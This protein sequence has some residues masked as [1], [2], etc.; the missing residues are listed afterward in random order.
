MTLETGSRDFLFG[1]EIIHLGA[2]FHFKCSVCRVQREEMTVKETGPD[3]GDRGTPLGGT[4]Q[5]N[6][7]VGVEYRIYCTKCTYQAA[8]HAS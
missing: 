4:M 5:A 3:F 1:S 6:T 8:R 7:Q 2:S